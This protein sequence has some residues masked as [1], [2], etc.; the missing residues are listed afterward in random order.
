VILKK[1]TGEI[2]LFRTSIPVTFNG[3]EA[4]LEMLVD[5]TML[6][7]ARKQEARASSAKSEFLARMSYEIR[8]PLNGIIGMTDILEKKKLQ[9]EARD[10]VGL[11]RRSAEV[12]LNIVNDI[13]DFSRIESGKMILDEVPFSLR[14]EIMY[15][16]DLAR[17][18]ID[19]SLVA[20]AFAVGDNVPDKV[21]GDP[22]R[23]RQILTNLIN[24]SI[25]NT[26]RGRIE[27]NC[28]LN[29]VNDGM[30]RLKFEISD[31]GKSFDKAVLK[32]IFGNYVNVESKVHQVD[33]ESGFGTILARQLVDLMG[34]ELSAESPSGLDGDQGKKIVFTIAVYSNEKVEK[35]LRFE[36]VRTFRDIKTLVITGNQTRDEDTLGMLHKLGLTMTVT[37]FQ[38]LTVN[39][40]RANLTHPESRYHLIVIVDDREFNGFDA[41][42]EIWENSLSNHFSMILISSNDIK[43]NLQKCNT[44]GIDNYIIKPFEPEELY[45]ALKGCFRQVDSLNPPAVSGNITSELKILVIEDNKMNQKVLGTMLKNIGYAPDFADDGFA[46]LIQAKTRRYD[47][48]FMDL[49]MPEMDGFESARKIIEYD[50][51][52]LIIAFTA[53]NMPDSK[54]KAELTGIREFVPKPVRM[55]DLKKL[56]S[57][58]FVREGGSI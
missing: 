42:R 13:L 53:D 49:I 58:Y 36:T 15:C 40:I 32:K 45:N 31:T 3:E 25:E 11:L 14:E 34:G 18:N 43:G 12:L 24:H 52:S 27:L 33:D 41:A 5:V 9:P 22:F 37:T 54:R 29:Q 4:S 23:L 1:E 57:R 20:L 10:I 6:E 35:N 46:G 2:I 47:I 39:Q 38:R 21:I 55:E 30:V 19:E 44:M 8:T 7:S 51:N 28:S 56:F 48:I 16:H 50:K 17:T 26:S